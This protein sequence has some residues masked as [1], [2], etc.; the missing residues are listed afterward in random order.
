MLFVRVGAGQ[1]I[2]NADVEDAVR[3]LAAGTDEQ[4]AL[5]ALAACRQA[6]S[7]LS[8][9]VTPQLAFEAMLIAIK[10]ALTCQPSSR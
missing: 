8:R 1:D 2:V 10:E 7:D 9:N 6:A 5:A 4:G 3:R